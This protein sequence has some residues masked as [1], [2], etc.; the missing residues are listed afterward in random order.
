MGERHG[1]RTC[2]STWPGISRA[3]R[4]A[5]SSAAPGHVSTLAELDGAGPA[6]SRRAFPV[7]ELGRPVAGRVRRGAGSAARGLARRHLRGATSTSPRP[8]WVS[9]VADQAS[10][11]ISPRA[12]PGRRPWP[13]TPTTAW[14][15]PTP[16]S[17][18]LLGPGPMVDS[19]LREERERQTLRPGATLA[20]GAGNRELR[21]ARRR[22]HLLRA[23]SRP[24]R[25][26]DRLPPAGRQDP[27]CRPPDRPPADPAHPRPGGRPGRHLDRPG[28]RG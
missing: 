5:V 7:A 9:P 11:P 18:A 21:G 27:G 26:L 15:G 8:S 17:R 13:G 12:Q 16:T 14:S 22:T 4:S 25:A 24:D 28:R 10:P 2:A 19:E 23:R 6:R 3:S 20:V 1:S